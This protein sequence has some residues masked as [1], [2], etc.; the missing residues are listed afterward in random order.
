M[1]DVPAEA[2]VEQG[3]QQLVFIRSRATLVQRTGTPPP[4]PLT[5]SSADSRSA[6]YAAAGDRYAWRGTSGP[7]PELTKSH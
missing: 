3:D 6:I 7:P 5:R 1:Y 2:V 4:T